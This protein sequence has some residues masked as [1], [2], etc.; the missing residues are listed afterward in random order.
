MNFSQIIIKS[1]VDEHCWTWKL[2][3]RGF[4]DNKIILN[5]IKNLICIRKKQ[6]N[7]INH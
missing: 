5:K 1:L 4:I 7:D 2:E 3:P 6:P